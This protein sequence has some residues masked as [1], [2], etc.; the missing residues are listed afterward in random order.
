MSR[1]LAQIPRPVKTLRA[2]PTPKWASM[3]IVRE[4][5]IAQ[6]DEVSR[7]GRV[8]VMAAVAGAGP[9]AERGDGRLGDVQL[10]ADL[11][12]QGLLGVGHQGVGGG[13]GLVG[14]EPLGL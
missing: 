12:C 10:L 6:A 7:N 14:L 2:A 5:Q 3:L 13:S 11:G 1:P 8:G 4:I 9:V